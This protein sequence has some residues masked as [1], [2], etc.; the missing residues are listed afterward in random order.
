[1]IL[2]GYRPDQPASQPGHTTDITLVWAGATVAQ[3]GNIV[4]VQLKDATGQV[5][6]EGIGPLLAANSPS[7]VEGHYPLNLPAS[8]PRGDYELWVAVDSA[9]SPAV[10]EK[11]S[12]EG[13][14]VGAIPVRQL[15]K[16]PVQWPASVNFG[17]LITFGGADVQPLQ[18]EGTGQTRMIDIKFLW[19]ARRPMP[20]AYTTFAHVVDAAGNIWGQADRTPQVDQ[21]ELPTNRWNKGE[22]I[23]DTFQISLKPDTPAG[24]YTLLAGLYHPQ[25][26]ERLPVVGGQAGQTTVEITSLV[27]P[28]TE[29]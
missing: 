5:W 16:P 26:L 6:I 22:W 25:T 19:Q 27:V 18:Q 10:S 28:F 8:M 29:H 13:Y 21:V 11:G 9:P 17:D 2:R 4:T 12:R 24:H 15:D 7:P 20:Q 14:K 3:A 23:V 1:V